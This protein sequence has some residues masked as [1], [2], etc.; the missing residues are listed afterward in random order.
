MRGPAPAGSRRVPGRIADGGP[1][2]ITGLEAFGTTWAGRVGRVAGAERGRCELG[3]ELLEHVALVGRLGVLQQRGQR[4]AVSS[5]GGGHG[6]GLDVGRLGQ[7]DHRGVGVVQSAGLPQHPH[8]PPR[9][10]SVRAGGHRPGMARAT[11]DRIAGT[12]PAMEAD[13]R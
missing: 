11:I 13:P 8:G 7:P 3:Q 12:L 6:V 9:R 4:L 2:P 5:R 10:G 1:S